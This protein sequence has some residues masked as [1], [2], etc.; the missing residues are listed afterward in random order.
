MSYAL[1]R[2]SFVVPGLI[3]TKQFR[4]D[5]LFASSKACFQGKSYYL[6]RGAILLT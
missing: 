2:S 6:N 1:G 4:N 3:I 5:A